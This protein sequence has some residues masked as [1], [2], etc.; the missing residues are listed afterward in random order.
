[1]PDGLPALYYQHHWTLLKDEVCRAVRD[2]LN[3]G[4]IPYDFNDTIVV[5]VKLAHH[6]NF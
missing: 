5:F 1:V 2:F 3:G 6:P 4:P